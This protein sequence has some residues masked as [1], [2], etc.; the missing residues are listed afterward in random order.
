[1]QTTL[2]AAHPP[3]R[4]LAGHVRRGC[5]RISPYQAGFED[6][7][8]DREYRNPFTPDSREWHYYEQGNEDAL[9]G[10]RPL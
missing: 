8:Y 7:R 9:L 4:Q 2:T 1:M 6:V 3:Q 10:E 5:H